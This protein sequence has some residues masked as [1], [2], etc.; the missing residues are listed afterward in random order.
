MVRVKDTLPS[1]ICQ[2]TIPRIRNLF[3]KLTE[4]IKM[5]SQFLKTE[6]LL[7]PNGLS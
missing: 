5:P 7:V 1:M 4:R 2:V 3:D 6:E